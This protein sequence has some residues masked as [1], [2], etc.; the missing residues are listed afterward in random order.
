MPS[1]VQDPI[2]A[3]TYPDP[4]PYYA[5]LLAERPLSRDTAL[6]LWVASSAAAVTAV[7]SSDRCRVRPPEEPVPRGLVG[8]PAGLIFG[9]LIRMNDGPGRCPL[10]NAVAGAIGA[11]APRIAGESAR[12]ARLLDEEL[13]PAGAA[14]RLQDF[15]FR[16]P[17]YA[18][19]SLLGAPRA[20][21]AT[22]AEWTRDL[23]RG[24]APAGDAA[25]RARA[26]QA[27]ERLMRFFVDVLASGE[28]VDALLG[29]LARE[30]LRGGVD[31]KEAIVANG[32]GLL[33]QACEATAGL[34]GNTLVALAAR[35]PLRK[36]V[37]AQP[38]LLP[39]VLA[40]VLRYDPP[41]QNT[42][43]F[44]ASAG[45]VGGQEMKEG[46]AVL[47]VLAAANRD[48]AANPDPQHF[49]P[50]RAEPRCFTF[51]LGSHQ[52]PGEA[53]ALGIAQAGVERLMTSGLSF[54]RLAVRH[55]Q[56]SANVRIPVF[57]EEGPS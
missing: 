3:V 20:D 22:V 35:E 13:R 16:L 37:L 17:V 11:V 49:D 29:R 31:D 57:A 7:L 6:G 42:R 8:S 15:A 56:P 33:S 28:A 41:V 43:R 52:C 18:V 19:A 24:F 23:V 45:D 5:S 1:V 46:E 30:A 12:C 34:I 21:L 44:V 50:S 48:P 2:A 53:L 10:R 4:Y 39:P 25:D 40:E 38:D 9:Q 54:E 36:R 27:A 32:V 55:Y 47:V 26:A 51:G 14:G